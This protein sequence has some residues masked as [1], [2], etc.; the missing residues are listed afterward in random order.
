MLSPRSKYL[1]V[2]DRNGSRLT[3]LYKLLLWNTELVGFLVSQS[4]LR[5]ELIMML[6][7][8]FTFAEYRDNC[9]TTRRRLSSV[10]YV[11]RKHT[12]ASSEG[13]WTEAARRCESLVVMWM[14]VHHRTPHVSR[15]AVVITETLC[16]RRDNIS[17]NY[18]LMGISEL[19]KKTLIERTEKVHY[20]RL[21]EPYGREN[22]I[23]PYETTQ[24]V[25][26]D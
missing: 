3:F 11:I 1:L 14:S 10:R 22:E 19:T 15:L 21:R 5:K 24:N 12:F 8:L 7:K 9:R 18:R 16:D 25:K 13:G 26:E 2:Y 17:R 6:F 4:R 20:F 23:R